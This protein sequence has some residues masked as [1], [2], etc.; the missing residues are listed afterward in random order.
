MVV[1]FVDRRRTVQLLANGAV[2]L[3][4]DAATTLCASGIFLD[5]ICSLM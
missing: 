3:Q 5:V 2:I 1:L 4:L